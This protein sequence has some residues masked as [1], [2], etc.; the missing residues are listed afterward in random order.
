MFTMS[1]QTFYISRNMIWMFQFT[2]NHRCMRS[3]DDCRYSNWP[4]WVGSQWLCHRSFWWRFCVVMLL[5]AFSRGC[6]GFG[7]KT[8]TS[9]FSLFITYLWCFVECPAG[10][11]GVNCSEV[12]KRGYYG[13]R[14]ESK[15]NC[16]VNQRCDTADGCESYLHGMQTYKNKTNAKSDEE[17]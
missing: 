15:C 14:C 9:F 4:S 1:L 17:T 11:W 16:T 3:F 2:H 8:K 6:R 10:T 13:R 12:C 5:F 7:H